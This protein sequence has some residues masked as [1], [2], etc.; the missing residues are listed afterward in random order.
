MS[1]QVRR[2]LY[3]STGELFRKVNPHLRTLLPMQ[4]KKSDLVPDDNRGYE[5]ILGCL[6]HFSLA[7]YN[8]RANFFRNVAT[9]NPSV[10]NPFWMLVDVNCHCN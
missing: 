9:R 8:E 2:T 7:F 3:F 4:F 1:D 10:A 5:F 6:T